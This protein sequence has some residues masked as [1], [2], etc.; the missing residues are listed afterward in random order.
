MSATDG[1]HLMLAL[2]TGWV[3]VRYWKAI[4]I[5]LAVV[6][7]AL[8]V[9]GVREVLPALSAG[10]SPAEPGPGPSSCGSTTTPPQP[11]PGWTSLP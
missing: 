9:L 4:L 11:R 7:T 2:A 10:P 8:V 6:L 3:L 5:A 1:F